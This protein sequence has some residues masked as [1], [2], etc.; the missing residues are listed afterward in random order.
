M[1]QDK[2]TRRGGAG[3]GGAGG[4]EISH[5]TKMTLEADKRK[6]RAFPSTDMKAA[7]E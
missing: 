5:A 6:G 1:K 2:L 3:R 4:Q 7:R